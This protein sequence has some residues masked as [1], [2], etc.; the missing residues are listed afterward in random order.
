MMTLLEYIYKRESKE[1]VLISMVNEGLRWF[2]YKQK[3]ASVRKD[4][5]RRLN[6]LSEEDRRIVLDILKRYSVLDLE[7]PLTTPPEIYL[8]RFLDVFKDYQDLS[9][10]D[11]YAKTL[12]EPL[13]SFDNILERL[14]LSLSEG[15]GLIKGIEYAYALGSCETHLKAKEGALSSV[16]K[17]FSSDYSSN[18]T[19]RLLD[20]ESCEE[21]SDLVRITANY[22]RG[23]ISTD[24]VK[25]GGYLF[26][27]HGIVKEE[28]LSKSIRLTRYGVKG[29][30]WDI[31]ML[32]DTLERM[33]ENNRTR[34]EVN[35]LALHKELLDYKSSDT[36]QTVLLS[37]KFYGFFE[38]CSP[39]R[40]DTAD[41]TVP[42]L[43]RATKEGFQVI[44][45]RHRILGM[46]KDSEESISAYI[47]TPSDIDLC[48][49]SLSLKYKQA[50]SEVND[51]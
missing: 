12:C 42:V 7:D 51:V 29:Y 11:V 14:F 32:E 13:A 1:A 33:R 27:P 18:Y 8:H 22:T 20:Q 31:S 46:M 44:D 47:L 43:L 26:T 25:E 49:K 19:N 16:L 50:I 38:R 3:I 28:E 15:I 23:V 9:D 40:I 34:E 6:E 41:R 4:I 2:H 24:I 36:I 5:A 10:S 30:Y 48:K 17:Y 37:S 45:G 35:I 21:A 39:S